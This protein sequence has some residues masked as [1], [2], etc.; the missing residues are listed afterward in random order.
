MT[1]DEMVKGAILPIPNE[2]IATY[3]NGKQICEVHII[4]KDGEAVGVSFE[5]GYVVIMTQYETKFVCKG[6][7]FISVW[8][9]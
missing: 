6:K 3:H 5:K 4:L 8:K 9:N 2:L 7:E 1:I